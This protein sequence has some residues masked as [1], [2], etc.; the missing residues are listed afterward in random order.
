[1]WSA[2]KHLK[3]VSKRY[4]LCT[5]DGSALCANPY[6]TAE[7]RKHEAP[8]RCAITVVKNHLSLAEGKNIE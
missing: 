5:N 6:K 4:N 7:Q 3:E 8:L 1:M 2:V